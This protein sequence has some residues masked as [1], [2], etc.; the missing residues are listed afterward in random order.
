[1]FYNPT[2]YQDYEKLLEIISLKD[3]DISDSTLTTFSSIAT[4][5]ESINNKK[6]SW[7]QYDFSGEIPKIHPLENSEDIEE[8]KKEFPGTGAWLNF[9]LDENIDDIIINHFKSLVSLASNLKGFKIL[10]I[11]S[12]HDIL[13]SPHS[14][15]YPNTLR[16]LLT[17]ECPKNQNTDVFG[18]EVNRVKMPINQ[19]DIHIFDAANLHSAWNFTKVK[20]K[21]VIIDIEKKFF[22]L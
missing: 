12:V 3:L 16:C 22:N 6:Y 13:L 14:D 17:I 5:H 20:W 19:Y 10:Q 21:F 9:Q 1:M 2:I 8:I 7:F 11:S 15:D 18:I 4:K